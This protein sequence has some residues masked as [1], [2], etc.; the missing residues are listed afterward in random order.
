MGVGG[1]LPFYTFLA[2]L[3]FPV[4]QHTWKTKCHTREA[5]GAIAD[6]VSNIR[7]ILLC[8]TV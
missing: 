8:G 2:K 1:E 5:P 3:D 4:L 7:K 6:P